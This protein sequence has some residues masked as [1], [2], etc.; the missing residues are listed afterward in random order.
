MPESTLTIAYSEL[1]IEIGDHLGY[2][3][4]TTNW[5]TDETNR[6]ANILERGQ[7]RFFFPLDPRIQRTH[8]WS[9]LYPRFTFSTDA[10][11]TTGTVAVT[12]GVVTLTSGTF[13]TWSAEGEITISGDTYDVDT[14]DG[15]TQLTLVDTSVTGIAAGT[16]YTIGHTTYDLPDD[17]ADFDPPMTYRP[18]TSAFYPSITHVPEGVLRQW[19]QHYEY[20]YRPLRLTIIPKVMNQTVGQRYQIQ[21]TPAPDAA[22]RLTYRYMRIPDAITAQKIYHHGGAPYSNALLYAC[23]AEADIKMNDNP[24]ANEMRYQEHIVQAIEFDKNTNQAAYLG[25]MGDPGDSDYEYT[26]DRTFTDWTRG[27]IDASGL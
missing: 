11:Y 22:Y 17:F 4:T 6:V 1:Q 3:R 25:H 7:R 10:S 5:S 13:P 2:T 24:G 15:D 26:E 19:R 20:F 18:G 9:F 23:L 27:P 14:R 21:M 12:N 8:K 16:S